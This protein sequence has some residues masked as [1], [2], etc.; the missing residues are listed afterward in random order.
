MSLQPEKTEVQAVNRPSKMMLLDMR[1]NHKN[2]SPD[3]L[4]SG[5]TNINKTVDL[6]S[7]RPILLKRDAEGEFPSSFGKRRLKKPVHG[8]SIDKSGA[9]EEA[10]KS[11]MNSSDTNVKYP[12]LEVLGEIVREYN[13]FINSV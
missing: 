2:K 8:I 11:S 5:S 12:S 6:T 1:H 3:T 7:I 4:D 10:I 13:I 9:N